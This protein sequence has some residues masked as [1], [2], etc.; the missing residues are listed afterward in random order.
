VEWG[1]SIVV[2]LAGFDEFMSSK[3]WAVADNDRR[4]T[5]L[6]FF[7]GKCLL[8][9]SFL[10]LSEIRRY[11]QVAKGLLMSLESNK[12]EYGGASAITLVPSFCIHRSRPD[13]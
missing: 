1:T 10:T 12:S 5:H 2:I 7:K 9:K 11:Y 8:T 3:F 13:E 6:A 4:A